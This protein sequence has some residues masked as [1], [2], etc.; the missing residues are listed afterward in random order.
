M[1]LPK[2]KT[3]QVDFDDLSRPFWV[4]MPPVFYEKL[5]EAAHELGMPQKALVSKAVKHF[6]EESK[7]EAQQADLPRT[8]LQ[9]ELVRKAQQQFGALRWSGVKKADR[10]AQMKKAA[11]ARWDK[12]RSD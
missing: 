9:E 12:K 6:I 2:K 11:Q 10:R 8:P 1:E 4:D 5:R 7:K 3:K